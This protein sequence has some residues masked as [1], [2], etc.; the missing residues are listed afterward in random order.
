MSASE[1]SD[2][3][4]SNHA[5]VAAADTIVVSNQTSNV[6]I[7]AAALLGND[8]DVDGNTLSIVSVGNA[9][10]GISGLSLSGGKITF[11]TGNFTA[12]QSFTYTLSDGVT[13]TVGS[14]TAKMVS[15]ANGTGQPD[16][17]NLAQAQYSGYVAS[18]IDLQ[19]GSDTASGG[20]SAIDTFLGA[21]GSDALTGGA[22]GDVL[23]G[24]LDADILTG[25]AGNDTFVFD[26]AL[27]GGNVDTVSDFKSGG[28]A[29]KIALSHAIFSN[30][31]TSSGTL[32]ASDF[33]SVSNGTGATATSFASGVHIIYDSQTGNLFYD[34][35]GGN[36]ASGRTLFATLNSGAGHP[37]VGVGDIIVGP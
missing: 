9:S 5:P 7:S 23:N 37:A 13:T 22:G 8:S 17:G 14:V 20:G 36:T 35:D 31:V 30:L 10:A 25:G 19:G 15:T 16:T 26:S 18:Y 11:S 33:G 12:D 3:I 27:G 21:K 34:S 1:S 29:D 6:T 24:G 28:D 2:F 4:A 32:G